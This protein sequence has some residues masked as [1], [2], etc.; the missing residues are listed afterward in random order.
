MTRSYVK[1]NDKTREE[2]VELIT[3]RNLSIRDAAQQMNINY[4]N[5]KAIYRTFR[6]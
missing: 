3:S 6:L 2:L 5:A 4:E 1:I